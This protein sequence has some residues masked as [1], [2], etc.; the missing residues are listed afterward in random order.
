MLHRPPGEPLEA[1]SSRERGRRLRV[2]PVHLVAEAAD[3]RSEPRAVV[4]DA[5]PVDAEEQRVRVGG[6]RPQDRQPVDA[7][8]RQLVEEGAA[9][10][11]GRVAR[12]VDP[13]SPF[14]P[15][16]PEVAPETAGRQRETRVGLAIAKILV[17][18]DRSERVRSEQFVAPAG[19]GPDR[20]GVAVEEEQVVVG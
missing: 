15:V 3:R 10:V 5:M 11:G 2:L 17:T 4:V 7:G 8:G 18:T 14:P 16:P 12:R 13:R 20:E 6:V 1:C 19:D 9:H